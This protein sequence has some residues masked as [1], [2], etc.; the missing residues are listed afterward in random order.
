MRAHS[1]LS[2]GEWSLERVVA[3]CG[4]RGDAFLIMTDHDVFTALMRFTTPE[5]LGLSFV[6]IT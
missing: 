2:D 5:Y 3:L 4:Q 1:T 6:E